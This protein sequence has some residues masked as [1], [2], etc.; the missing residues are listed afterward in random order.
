MDIK[1]QIEKIISD[2]NEQVNLIR[3]EID[4]IEKL[5]T[6]LNTLR[7]K[8]HELKIENERQLIETIDKKSEELAEAKTKALLI[9]KRF[10]KDTIN[11]G[12]SGFTHAGK[13]TLLQAIS[14]LNDSEIPKADE[15]SKNGLHPTTAI[16]SQIFNSEEEYAEIVYRDDKE[17]MEFINA[18]LRSANLQTIKSKNEV[19]DLDIPENINGQADQNL[20]KDRL[21]LIKESYP[22]FKRYVGEESDRIKRSSFNKL[23]SYVSYSKDDATIR[24]YPAVKEVKI[25]CNF[26]SLNDSEVKLCLVDLP[27]FGEFDSV[28][29]IQTNNLKEKVD[30]VLFVYKTNKDKAIFLKEYI[31]CFNAIKKIHPDLEENDEFQSNFLSFFINEDRSYGDLYKSHVAQT[32]GEDGIQKYGKNYKYCNFP[33][34][35]NGEPNVKEATS[36]LQIILTNLA[37]TLPN[38]D[39]LL[40]NSFKESMD[41]SSISFMVKDLMTKAKMISIQNDDPSIFYD[42][43]VLLRDNFNYALKELLKLYISDKEIDRSFEMKVNSL[44]KEI[45]QQLEKDL[46]YVATKERPTWEK[47][48]TIKADNLPSTFNSELQ[49]IWVA[50]INVYEKLDDEFTSKL[51]KLKQDVLEK[52]AELTGEFVTNREVD[53]FDEIT[54]K[55]KLIP[56]NQINHAFTAL[57]SLKQDFRQNVYPYIFRDGINYM[58]EQKQSDNDLQEAV[59]DLSDL[60]VDNYKEQ[61]LTISQKTNFEIS[62]TIKRYYNSSFFLIGALHTFMERI[63]FTKTHNNRDFVEFCSIFRKSVYPE[64]YGAEADSV[65]IEELKKLLE[66]IKETVSQLN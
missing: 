16:C 36:N 33:A 43:G 64:E 10:E 15:T 51:I 23:S 14:G 22:Y 39:G 44:K 29:E 30:H 13:S 7:S 17:F 37:G 61:L 42:K 58:M 27:G 26:P 6:Q 47:Y 34:L 56:N 57:D 2:R 55:L 25:Y 28:D 49:R 48:M 63:S 8:I 54:E 46:F 65:K 40:L 52:F 60:T 35:V 4:N 41:L 3:N 18:H 31:D 19:A 5:S 32:I 21:R 11:I 66:D 12:V 53:N 45:D 59:L 38:M 1:T 50:I 24:F 9:R 20:I 62:N